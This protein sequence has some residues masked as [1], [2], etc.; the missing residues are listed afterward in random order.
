MNKKE[1]T[2]KITRAFHK[3]S[4][5]VKKYS[6]EILAVT[7]VVGIVASTVMAC[8]ATKKVDDIL[9]ETK[10]E[11]EKIHD[12]SSNPMFADR[13][14]EQDTKKDLTITYVQTGLKIAKVYAPAVIIGSLS[15]SC[16]LASNN[17]LR[18]RNAALAAAYATVDRGFKAYRKRVIER[19]GEQADKEIRY[20]LQKKEIRETIIDENGKEKTVKKTVE[21]VGPNVIDDYSY[22]FDS[23]C[24]GWDKNP[25]Y[26]LMFLRAKQS[27]FNDLLVAR[28]HV[29]LN[30]VLDELGMNR[31]KG[32]QVIGWVYEP[33]KPDHDGDNF[34]DFGFMNAYD[35][36]VRDFVNGY[37][38]AIWLKF[39]VDGYILDKTFY[40]KE[41]V[42]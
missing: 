13:Y 40:G 22:L 17:I 15:I 12:V 31:T 38:P 4:F 11:I 37:E 9:E 41:G 32:G 6:P 35:E 16:M 24:S 3:T 7:G 36:K 25:E 42:L 2:T 23:H 21:V 18:K 20:D 14:S 34:I 26:S 27:Y 8:K 5:E 28:G 39:N 19:Y 33:N 10:N 30:E 1:L 29:F